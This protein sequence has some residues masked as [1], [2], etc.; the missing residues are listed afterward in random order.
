MCGDTPASGSRP[1]PGGRGVQHAPGAL[2]GEAA[3]AGVEEH[4]RADRRAAG[5]R[6]EAGPGPDQVRIERPRG[7]AA[8]R[9]HPVLAALADQPHQRVRAQLQLVDVE[10][11][12]LGDARPGAVEELEQRPVPQQPGVRGQVI[13]TRAGRVEQALHLR[14]GDRLGQPPGR[15]RRR[16]LASRVGAGEALGDREGVQAADR[17][18]GPRGRTDRQRRVLGVALAQ[19]GEEFRHVRRGDVAQPGLAAAGQH[20]GVPAQV[21]P[22]GLHRAGRQ[23]ALHDQVLQVAAERVGQRKGHQRLAQFRTWL[24]GVYGRASASATGS[25]VSWPACVDR[26]RASGASA[27]SASRQPRLAIST[28][29]GSVTLVSA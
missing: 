17:D 11:G 2:P 19:R 6:G 9:H 20:R 14:Q 29:Y 3:A 24:A 12:R 10:A 16:D 25:Q 18:H 13:G 8:H 4:R 26:P 7:V 28:A 5:R 23:P 21:A 22:V 27:R 15:R 1:D